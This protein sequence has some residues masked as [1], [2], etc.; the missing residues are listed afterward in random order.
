METIKLSNIQ[1]ISR[2]SGTDAN[3][4]HWEQFQVDYFAEQVDGVCILCNAT[5]IDGW[6]CLDDGTEEVC[7]EHIE[8]VE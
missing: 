2:L 8:F 3:G 4:N 7:N 5:L 6:V 1:G